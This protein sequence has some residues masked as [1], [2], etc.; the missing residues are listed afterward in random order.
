MRNCNSQQKEKNNLHGNLCP[1]QCCDLCLADVNCGSPEADVLFTHSCTEDG[2]KLQ[3][4]SSISRTQLMMRFIKCSSGIVQFCFES[5]ILVSVEFLKTKAAHIDTWSSGIL[6]TAT[7][8][9]C[10]TSEEAAHFIEFETGNCRVQ[11]FNS[12]TSGTLCS[13]PSYEK[14]TNRHA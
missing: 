11:F 2:I 4:L 9:L 7:E 3:A 1:A 5:L 14:A 10:E 8:C 13:A 6:K 12:R